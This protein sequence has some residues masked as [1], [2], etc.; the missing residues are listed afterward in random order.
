LA[1]EGFVKIH[2]LA[3]FM[4]ISLLAFPP[5]GKGMDGNRACGDAQRNLASPKSRLVGHW[6]DDDGIQYY[7]GSIDPSTHEGSV[8]L[9][10][11]DEDKYLEKLRQ[12]TRKNLTDMNETVRRK[13]DEILI[14][15]A[16]ELGGRAFPTTY[17]ILSYEPAGTKIALE[18]DISGITEK[19]FPDTS[20]QVYWPV[21]LVIDMDGKT[22]RSDQLALLEYL[23]KDAKE[24]KYSEDIIAR[25]EQ[26]FVNVGVTNFFYIDAKTSPEGD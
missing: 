2:K 16:H 4:F 26:S 22:M 15:R 13:T 5:C 3:A 21:Y 20:N 23:R 24:K 6:T 17:R 9:V 1:R 11:P 19:K 10:Y 14:N 7:F 18:T 25:T 8:I 12:K